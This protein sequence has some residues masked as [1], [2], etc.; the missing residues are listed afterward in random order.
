MRMRAWFDL[1]GLSRTDA[2]DEAGIRKSAARINALIDEQVAAGIARSRIVLAGFSQGG[3]MV[4]QTGLRQLEPL[5]GLMVLS[6]YL[7]LEKTVAA[8]LTP[9]GRAQQ[10]LM[11]HG[12]QDPVLTLSMGTHSRNLLQSLGVTVDW[13]DYPMAHEV[14]RQEIEDISAWLSVRLG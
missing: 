10:I 14:S 11:C 4:L 2:Q 7:P 6:G 5:A 9:A 12:R 13:H 8:E 3:A 1:L